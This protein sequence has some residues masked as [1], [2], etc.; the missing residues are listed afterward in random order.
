MTNKQIIIDGVDVS[1]CKNS[2]YY[3]NICHCDLCYTEKTCKDFKNCYYKQLK[4]KEREYEEL[5]RQF[6]IM[7]KDMLECTA[8]RATSTLKK[9]LDQLKAE[10]DELKEEVDQL[11]EDLKE[12]CTRCAITNQLDKQIEDLQAEN[13]KLKTQYNCYACGNCKGR[14]DYINMARHCENAIK[15]NHK[16][17]QALDEIEEYCTQQ[18]RNMNLNPN[19]LTEEDILD[20][21]N[22]AK[23]QE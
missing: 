22:K 7:K 11:E 13:E 15:T 4:R 20:I 23:E 18:Q 10:N 16:Y 6:E 12:E 3:D 2:R 9:Q 1:G 5:E 19:R 14:E 21:I 17:K 8:C